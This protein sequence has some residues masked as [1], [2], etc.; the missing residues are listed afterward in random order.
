MPSGRREVVIGAQSENLG[1]MTFED[2]NI[3]FT[4]DLSSYNYDTILRDKQG[5]INSLYE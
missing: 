1:Q 3:T 4:G 2:R 5:N